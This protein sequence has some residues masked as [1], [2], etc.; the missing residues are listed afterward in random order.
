[1]QQARATHAAAGQ[2][3]GGGAHGGLHALHDGYHAHRT[4]VFDQHA[5]HARLVA[6]GGAV[7]DR[8]V[9]EVARRPLCPKRAA[10]GTTPA[11]AAAD[12]GPDH[13]VELVP[14]QAHATPGFHQAGCHRAD[15]GV[16]QGT[17]WQFG[18][19]RRQRRRQVDAVGGKQ[20]QWRIGGSSEV[21]GRTAARRDALHQQRRVTVQESAAP[22][23]GR[24]ACHLPQR[25]GQGR[26]TA[27]FEHQ[28]TLA[29]QGQGTRHRG[30]AGAAAH[31]DAVV[32]GGNCWWVLV[33]GS[34][35]PVFSHVQAV[36]YAVY[37]NPMEAWTGFIYSAV[38]PTT[39]RKGNTS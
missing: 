7:G 26:S 21:D 6:Q 11:A 4:A 37:R 5:Q 33:Q 8:L 38:I 17:D 22:G 15:Q 34:V 39:S 32:A 13:L 12:G 23:H 31:D 29:G 19:Q 36:N 30:P 10:V 14:C 35:Y 1:M 16:G 25:T 27:L 9:N 3:H 2:H 18:A 28:Y 24:H 20:G